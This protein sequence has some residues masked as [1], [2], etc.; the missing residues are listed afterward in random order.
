MQ[1]VKIT[2]DVS[3][4]MTPVPVPGVGFL[5]INAYVIKTPDGVILVDS[6][7]TQSAGEFVKGVAGIVDPA[8]IKWIWLTH[9]DRDHTG[10]LLEILD[11]APNGRLMTSFTSFGHM[12]V[13]PEPVPPERLHLINA[14]ERHRLGD[15]EVIAFRPPLYDNPGT[16]GLFEPRTRTLVSSDCFGAPQPSIQDATV[17]DVGAL[18]DEQ[19]VMGQMMWG[20]ADSPWVH[21]VDKAKF[22]GALNEVKTFD[23]VLTLSTHIPPI[24]GSITPHLDRLAA[25]PDS[26]PAPGLDQATL[27]ALLAEMEPPHA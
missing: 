7:A 8:D 3:A 17:P 20:S 5:P 1:I 27:E 23:P 19:V 10:G 6:C 24:R 18:P 13:G 26:P 9:P 15:T 22:A 16:V 11:A 14:G 12:S 25:L 2:E 4:L 21:S